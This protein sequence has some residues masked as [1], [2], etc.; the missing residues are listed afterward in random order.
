MALDPRISLMSTP[1]DVRTAIT[2]GL[3]NRQTAREMPIREAVLQQQQELGAMS[4]EQQKQNAALTKARHTRDLLRAVRGKDLAERAE[5]IAQNMPVLD[6]LGISRQDVLEQGLTDQAL[7]QTL[8]GLDALLQQAP[9]GGNR[10]QFGADRVIKKDDDTLVSAVQRRNPTTGEIE[11][12]EVPIKGQLASSIGETAEGRKEREVSTAVEKTEKVGD[13]EIEQAVELEDAIREAKLTTAQE[14]SNIAVAQ[15]RNEALTADQVGR[16]DNA[17]ETGLSAVSSL[18]DINRGLELLQQIETG[19]MTA[20]AKEITDFFGTTS[21]EIGELN[22]ILAS[23][24]LA[25]LSA[26]TGAISEGERQF[27]ER[28]NTSLTQGTGFN[29]AQLNR[30]KNIYNREVKNGLRAAQIANDEFA[31]GIFEDSM[32]AQPKGFNE[33]E[34][35]IQL[36]PEQES[37]SNRDFINNL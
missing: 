10:F 13:I 15:K 7:D 27:I 30:L 28:M 11:V 32:S 9:T 3:Q 4:I 36:T 29:I 37:M 17:I 12:V 8:V 20:R 14:L 26:F 5:I 19:G 16:L 25:G 34:G 6:Q 24:V 2:G 22:N 33:T 21:G 35:A 1:V 23:N 31:I 18:P